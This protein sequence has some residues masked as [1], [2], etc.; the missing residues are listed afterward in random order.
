[1]AKRRRRTGND[2]AR[3]VDTMRPKQRNTL[4]PDTMR[5]SRFVDVFLWRGTENPTTVQ[6]IGAWLFGATFAGIGIAFFSM[7]PGSSAGD[8]WQLV[9]LS[10]VF[11][12]LGIKIFRNGFPKDQH[13]G[14]PP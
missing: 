1:M 10:W 13:K 6:R 5:N 14:T 9:F 4:W 3:F 12:L 7:I 2:A 11:I 8:K